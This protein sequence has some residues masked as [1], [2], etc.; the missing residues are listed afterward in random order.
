MDQS[1]K[2]EEKHEL[3]KVR[4]VPTHAS[5]TDAKDILQ[6]V[7]SKANSLKAQLKSRM[8]ENFTYGSVRALR[9]MKLQYLKKE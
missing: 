4:R 6:P 3:G 9:G 5:I 1:T 7:H 8:R 2:S